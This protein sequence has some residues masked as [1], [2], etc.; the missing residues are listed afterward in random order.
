M[1]VRTCVCMYVCMHVCMYVCASAYC[2]M[3]NPCSSDSGFLLS[4]SDWSFTIRLM[5]YN[6]N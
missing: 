4:L 3:I 6:R 1:Y 5:P 2:V